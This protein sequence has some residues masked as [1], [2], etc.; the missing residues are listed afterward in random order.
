MTRSMPEGA[1]VGRRRSRP[2]FNQA[3]FAKALR[4]RVAEQGV[5]LLDASKEIGCAHSS[6]SRICN[7]GKAPNVETYLRI[8]KWMGRP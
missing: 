2:L 4:V 3:A 5:T 7:A 1:G 8:M 6:L